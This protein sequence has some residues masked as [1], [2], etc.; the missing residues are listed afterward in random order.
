MS[1]RHRKAYEKKQ[2]S[3]SEAVWWLIANLAVLTF[4]ILCWAGCYY[5]FKFPEKPLNYQVLEKLGRLGSIKPFTPLNAP[6]TRSASPED[7]YELFYGL[8]AEKIEEFNNMLMRGYITNYEKIPVYRY[9]NGEFRILETRPLK[10]DDFIYPGLLIKARAFVK[11]DE[12]SVSSP[13][14]L[15]IDYLIP[16]DVKNPQQ[17]FQEGDQLIVKKSLHCASI[18][19]VLK[20]GRAEDPTLRCAVIPLAYNVYISPDGT[21]VPLSTP[22]HINV[23]A[24]FPM[25]KSSPEVTLPE[26]KEVEEEESPE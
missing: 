16:T 21:E 14:P 17:S 1:N 3:L 5:V 11:A 26:I 15:V 23:K 7:L 13:Y 2:L 22:D 12:N 24:D 20:E 19:N 18:L 9:L 10:E 6:P 8:D 25:F 4:S